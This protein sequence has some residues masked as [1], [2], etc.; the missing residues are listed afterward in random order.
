MERI[1]GTTAPINSKDE[2]EAKI[3]FIPQNLEKEPEDFITTLGF[4]KDPFMF[5]RNQ[6]A[7]FWKT[8]SERLGDPPEAG[9]DDE[10]E[11]EDEEEEQEGVMVIE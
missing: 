10:D 6:L 9:Q 7:V 2:L 4:F 8:L 3:R 11:D 1:D 5:A